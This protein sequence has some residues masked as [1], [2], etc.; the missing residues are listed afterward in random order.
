MLVSF[1]VEN[2]LS[3]KNR[4]KLDFNG[5]A[6]KEFQQNIHSS[7]L[8]FREDRILKAL[9]LYGANSSGKSNL[10]KAFAF[11]RN[12]ILNSSKESQAGQPIN[13]E[14][15][16][17]STQTENSPSYFEIE[18]I[19]ENVKYLYGVS[20]T[21]TKIVAE[22]LFK[23]N[24][25]KKYELLFIRENEKFDYRNLREGHLRAKIQML[26]EITR[27][28]ALFLSVLAQFNMSIARQITEW[29]SNVAILFESH[30]IELINYTASLLSQPDYNSRI[31]HIFRNS[32]LDIEYIDATIKEKEPKINIDSQFLSRYILE[33]ENSYK[34][35]TKHK[36]YDED[37]YV[38]TTK[39]ELLKN[40]S[41]GTQKFF[42]LLGPI[43]TTLK[44][45]SL[46]W[47]DEL[48]SRFHTLM[49][50]VILR[51][52]N[53]NMNNPNGAQLVFTLHNTDPL[54]KILRRDQMI[55]FE[56]DKYGATTFYSLYNKLPKV[57]SDA[58]FE[59][60]YLMGKYGA[61]PKLNSQLDLFGNNGNLED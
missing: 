43:I 36:K 25:K 39:F 56:K 60:E 2:Y 38:D 61:I 40:E 14:P 16:R 41:L 47:I 5:G 26:T 49:L 17:L 23:V 21:S 48:D 52:F 57:R 20:T 58:S 22:W 3:F 50:E 4:I 42:G 6:I 9:A 46:L 51:M 54:K 12:L 18:M 45:G 32:D 53:S 8:G 27:P 33:E 19:V 10:L 13:V 34:V 11:I 31:N 30:N 28:N 55:F 59:K 44:K 35:N 7:I 29:F 1:S 37:K 15:F 24:K